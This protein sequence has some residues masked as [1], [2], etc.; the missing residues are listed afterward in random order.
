M[1]ELAKYKNGNY[2]VKLMEDGTKIKMTEDDYFEAEFPDSIDLKITNQCDLNCPM[3]H[4]KS[5]LNGKEGNLLEPFLSTLVKGTEL[6][7]GGGNP[8]SHTDLVE[9]LKRMKK[10]G[11]IC[12]LTVNEQHFL[13]YKDILENLIKNKLIYGLGISLNECNEKTIDFA[14]ENKNVVFHVINGIFDSYN[15]IDGK[16]LKILILGYKKF[17]RGEDFY[18]EKVEKLMQKTKENLPKIFNGFANVC[19]D[20]LAL[21]QL[22]VKSL[23]SFEEWENYYMGDDGES[24]MYIDLVEKK[25]AKS[26]TSTKRYDIHENIKNMFKLIKNEKEKWKD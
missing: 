20:N 23:V 17:G 11:V 18:S 13:K 22:N 19:F 8:L 3:C 16:G 4:E 1:K 14:K 9:F 26:S 21:K 25:F 7:I 2:F 10:N 15:K 12:N 5:D 24:T 6:A